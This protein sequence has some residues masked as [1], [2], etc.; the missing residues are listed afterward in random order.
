MQIIDKETGII[1]DCEFIR[2]DYKQGMGNAIVTREN[3]KICYY[4]QGHF[5]L[6]DNKRGALK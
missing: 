6:Y 5:Y 1:R 4:K 2:Y 3:G